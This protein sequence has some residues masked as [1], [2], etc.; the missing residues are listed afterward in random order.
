MKRKRF[1]SAELRP[2]RTSSA[3]EAPSVGQR[4]APL[5]RA[6]APG[7][8]A[9]VVH[10]LADGRLVL[11]DRSAAYLVTVRPAP[12]GDY[13]LLRSGRV[14]VKAARGV[15]VAGTPAA[16]SLSQPSP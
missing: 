6:T 11:V 3:E 2:V 4:L 10:E 16:P 15:S 5:A 13:A 1:A 9:R 14:T 7:A 12:H 8:A